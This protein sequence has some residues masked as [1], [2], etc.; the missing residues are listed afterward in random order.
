[1]GQQ[2]KIWFQNRRT[3]WKKQ[4]NISN[5][6]AAELMKAKNTNNSSTNNSLTTSATANFIHGKRSGC[7]DQGGRLIQTSSSS[8]F[9]G[10]PPSITQMPRRTHHPSLF[11]TTLAPSVGPSS[12]QS[13]HLSEDKEDDPHHQQQLISEAAKWPLALTA[14]NVSRKEN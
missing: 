1:M 3:K 14:A 12:P 9:I 6:E 8:S 7:F 13:T 2:V 5:A 4:E 11:Q 10:T